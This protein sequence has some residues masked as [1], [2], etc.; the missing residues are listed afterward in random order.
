[1]RARAE[2]GLMKRKVNGKPVYYYWVYDEGNRRVYRS[3]GERM[4]AKAMEYVMNLREQG[5]LGIKDRS[6]VLLKDFTRDFFIPE[7]CPIVRN[8]RMHGRNITNS[9]CDIRRR[10]LTMHIIPHMGNWPISAITKARV[11]KW[12]MDL[13]QMDK[14]SRTS[15]NSY[16]DTLKQ[17]MEEA[18]R[19]GLIQTNPCEKIERLGSDSTRRAAFTTE[20]VKLLIGKPEDW[21]NAYIRLMCLTAAVTGMRVGEV[22]ALK[23][24]AITDTAIHVRASFSDFDGYKPPKNGKD[25]V[26][27]IPASLRDELRKF[28]PANGG[29]I[30]SMVNDKPVSNAYIKKILDSRLKAVG[31]KGKT[32]HSFRAYFNTEMMAANVNETVVRAV[33]GHQSPDMTEHYL[34]LETGEFAEIRNVQD[35]ILKK[36]LA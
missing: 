27:P 36:V 8:A 11:N 22:R 24:D 21:D 7:K 20:E 19:E 15:A 33:I 26:T 35:G 25:R 4:K 13:P 17:V 9:T 18:V 23:P 1:M 5:K 29:Y 16:Y 3:T 12:L 6:M 2:F 32:F 31:I 14:V 28:S 30:F 10:A 34:H